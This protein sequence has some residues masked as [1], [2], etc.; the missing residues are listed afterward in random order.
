MEVDAENLSPPPNSKDVGDARRVM[1]EK[2]HSAASS[3]L[4]PFASITIP[5]T[6][7]ESEFSG[8]SEDLPLYLSPSAEQG[9]LVPFSPNAHWSE[10]L[11]GMK[12]H[13]SQRFQAERERSAD[14]KEQIARNAVATK[15]I[16][17]FK[18]MLILQPTTE[19][20][21]TSWKLIKDYVNDAQVLHSV[22]RHI[23]RQ[24]DR[25]V[26]GDTHMYACANISFEL[27]TAVHQTCDKRE[28]Y[29]PLCCELTTSKGDKDPGWR[30]I[31]LAAKGVN[32]QFYLAISVKR[33]SAPSAVTGPVKMAFFVSGNR[34]QKLGEKDFIIVNNHTDYDSDEQ[35][36]SDEQSS[37]DEST[38][39]DNISIACSEYDTA[40]LPIEPVEEKSAFPIMEDVNLSP[41]M[42]KVPSHRSIGETVHLSQ[43]FSSLSLETALHETPGVS[44]HPVASVNVEADLVLDAVTGCDAGDRNMVVRTTSSTYIIGDRQPVVKLQNPVL[45]R[46]N[47]LYEWIEGVSLSGWMY[48]WS[49]KYRGLSAQHKRFFVLRDNLLCYYRSPPAA[50][51]EQGK[52]Y[53]ISADTSVERCVHMFQPCL[54]VSSPQ[55]DTLYLTVE[56]GAGM[57]AWHKALQAAISLQAPGKT[58]HSDERVNTIFASF[59]EA[60]SAQ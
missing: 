60:C 23:S 39:D 6:T 38:D 53:P 40:P 27:N 14:Y 50:E 30:V 28:K 22:D 35:C 3:P 8:K 17:Q 42:V 55:A 44:L 21:A 59:N 58:K 16:E 25:F 4:P 34:S 57:E 5:E 15:R 41:L 49:S 7:I 9:G 10:A 56:E 37:S 24:T 54:K 13:Q 51:Y 1:T 48:K 11:N 2:A 47:V 29:L 43:S 12:R 32:G 31:A 19:E 20:L 33:T 52:I 18:E 36:S 46:D 45:I 26:I